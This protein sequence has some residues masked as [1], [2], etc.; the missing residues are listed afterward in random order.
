MADELFSAQVNIPATSA[1]AR[2]AVVNTWGLVADSVVSTWNTAVKTALAN[3]YD[4]FSGYRAVKLAP[5]NAVLKV[6][7]LS[8]P[9][10]RAP[11]YTVTLGLSATTTT[12]SAPSELAICMSF[13]GLFVSGELQRRKRGRVYLGPWGQNA[14]DPFGVNGSRPNVTVLG[15]IRGAGAALVAASAAASTW[16][17]AVISNVGGTPVGHDVVNGWVDDAWDIQRRR[18]LSPLSRVVF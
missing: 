9:I 1:I 11:V 3:F 5:A 17:W 16:S 8:D 13:Q 2:D 15:Q 10:P 18:G 4:A 12:T 14:E 7:R 6:Y